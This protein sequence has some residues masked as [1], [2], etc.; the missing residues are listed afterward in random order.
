MSLI[1]WSDPEEML[2]LLAEYVADE[3]LAEQE[4]AERRQFLNELSA[5]LTALASVAENLSTAATIDRLRDIYD[6]QPAEFGRDP[7]LVHLDDCIQE[8]E[9]I[10]AEAEKTPR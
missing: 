6:S 5:A 2:G 8:L 4:D 7:A 10:V 3:R 9:R 1:N